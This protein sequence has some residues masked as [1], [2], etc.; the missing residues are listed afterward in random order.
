MSR[1][2]FKSKTATFLF[3]LI[4]TFVLLLIVYVVCQSYNIGDPNHIL[5]E[6]S[7][8]LIPSMVFVAYF[9]FSKKEIK[10]Y[11]NE[12]YKVFDQHPKPMW[13][14]EFDS[15]RFVLVNQTASDVYGYSKSEFQ[16]MSV[17]DVR[18]HEDK[19]PFI[20][21]YP[22]FQLGVKRQMISRHILKNGQTV[23]VEITAQHIIFRKKQ[24][25]LVS[26]KDITLELEYQKQ[27]QRL[28]SVAE[29]TT[30][31]VLITNKQGHIEWV[32]E[33]F[34]KNT[35]YAL[36]EAI[37]K[38]PK[39]LLHGEATDQKQYVEMLH[40]VYAG[41]SYQCEI[42]NYKKDGTPFWVQI[43]I[44]PIKNG[45]EIINFVIIQTDINTLKQQS[46]A[47]QAHFKNLRGIAFA[48]SH[49]LR[50]P[51]TNI[52]GLLELYNTGT[53]AEEVM[54]LIKKSAS[55]LDAE[56]K[57]IIQQTTVVPREVKRA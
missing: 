10:E 29:K 14:Y 48:T 7:L 53:S 20:A 22:E 26:V 46:N 4:A 49:K 25:T 23:T 50:S 31:G 28:S 56:I 45:E 42:L 2:V 35:G 3:I 5:K 12:F 17:L 16:T 33:A 34:E 6:V 32:N 19:A 40:E 41:N 38:R 51:L 9:T 43:N 21:N 15:K 18:P 52:L 54:P 44:T 37:G 47:L 1:I 55:A 27:I 39:D 13:I 30:S 11:Q 8:F 36:A 57:E 24:C